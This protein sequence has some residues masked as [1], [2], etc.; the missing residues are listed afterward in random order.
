M[1][2]S[3]YSSLYPEGVLV[4]MVTKVIKPK[5]E[6]FYKIDIRYSVDYNKVEY[7]YLIFNLLKDE[8]QKIKEEAEDE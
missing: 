2:T 1:V 3:G 4:G 8:E 7:G 6:G 5:G